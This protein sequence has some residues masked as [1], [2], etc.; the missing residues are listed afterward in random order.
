MNSKREKLS[1]PLLSTVNCV[2]KLN[3]WEGGD[4]PLGSKLADHT[5]PVTLCAVGLLLP[6]PSSMSATSNRIATSFMN[7]PSDWDRINVER[8]TPIEI[9]D[10]DYRFRPGSRV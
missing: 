5:P 6:H 10:A 9:I 7:V 1:V 8:Q 4:P 3:P 2:I